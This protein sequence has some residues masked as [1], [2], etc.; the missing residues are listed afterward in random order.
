MNKIDVV[1]IRC[2]REMDDFIRLP[3]LIYQGCPQ[4]VPD[5]V[6]DVRNLFDRHKNPAYEF[7]QIQPFVAYCNEVPVGRI[8]G[9]INRKANE[10]W[11]TRNVRFSMIEF[12]D[13][14][15]VSKALIDVVCKWGLSLGM[16]TIQGP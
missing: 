15:S 9:I 12:V 8:V 4:Y 3:Y 14:P 10:K 2:K 11:K 16:D 5:M 7:S 13:D 6:K 1:K